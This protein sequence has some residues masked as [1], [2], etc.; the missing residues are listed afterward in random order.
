MLSNKN[1]TVIRKF[2]DRK[3]RELYEVDDQYPRSGRLT[4]KRKAEL[5]DHPEYD[6]AAFIEF[7]VEDEPEQE[8]PE[9][10]EAKP[11]PDETATEDETIEEDATEEESK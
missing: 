6:G 2:I 4:K 11:E 3:T 1:P 5:L 9:D 7:A 8:A 10:Q